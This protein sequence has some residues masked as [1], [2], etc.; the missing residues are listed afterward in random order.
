MHLSRT[1]Q[2]CSGSKPSLRRPTAY[3]HPVRPDLVLADLVGLDLLLVQEGLYL[4]GASLLPG[5]VNT[6]TF[7][8]QV[9]VG[10]RDAG[11]AVAFQ[12]G[13]DPRGIAL[14]HVVDAQ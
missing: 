12:H 8:R 2:T 6:S 13:T 5:Q 9:A 10:F 1:R 7:V 4:L 14:V 11:E 3:E